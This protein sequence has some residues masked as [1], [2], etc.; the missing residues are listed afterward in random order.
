MREKV[1]ISDITSLHI[2]PSSKWGTLE[3]KALN[4]CLYLRDCGA[5]PIIL[6]HEGSHLDFEA[7]KES[8]KCIYPSMIPLKKMRCRAPSFAVDQNHQSDIHWE[9]S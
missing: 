4:D 6:C 2:C 9:S 7:Q 8:I 3:K 1:I 5:N